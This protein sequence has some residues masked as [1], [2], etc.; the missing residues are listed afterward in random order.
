MQAFLSRLGL[1]TA[2]QDI[3]LADD[4][5]TH[6]AMGDAQEF[7]ILL[8]HD[9]AEVTTHDG[10]NIPLSKMDAILRPSLSKDT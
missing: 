3:H 5:T 10:L 7:H 8:D 1:I 2:T 9:A 6:V 4:G